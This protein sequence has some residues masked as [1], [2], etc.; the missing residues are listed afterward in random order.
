MNYTA[1]ER[2]VISMTKDEFI[3]GYM[4][5]SKLPR[6]YRTPDG[7]HIPGNTARIAKPCNCGVEGCTGWQMTYV[8]TETSN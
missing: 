8:N 5:R 1:I 2:R 6:E 7:F 3:D 4:V